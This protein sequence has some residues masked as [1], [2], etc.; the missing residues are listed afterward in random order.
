MRHKNAARLLLV[1]MAGAIAAGCGSSDSESGTAADSPPA[2][3]R[4]PP[5]DATDPSADTSPDQSS[6]TSLPPGAE[7]GLDDINDDGEPDPTCGT[8]DFGAGLVIRIP[9]DIGGYAHEPEEGTRLIEGSLYRLPGPDNIDLTGISGENLSAR[10]A[11][12]TALFILVFNSDN[13]FATGSDVIG[14]T[15]TL[16]ATI[17]LINSQFSAGE[18]QVRGHTDATGAVRGNQTLSEN[19]ARVVQQY[20]LDHAVSATAVTAVGLGSTQPLTEEA[21]PDGSPDPEGQRFN[22]RVEIVVRLPG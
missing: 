3:T 7:P 14:S 19:R 17:R 16:D 1:L 11:D 20:L 5:D 15:D 22:R 21:N 18:I 13:L 2:V 12:G 8:Q 6:A 4:T 9:C 10:H